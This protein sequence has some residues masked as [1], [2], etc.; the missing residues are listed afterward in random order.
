MIAWTWL[1]VGTVAGCLFGIVFGVWFLI[2]L[3]EDLIRANARL[4]EKNERL[5]QRIKLIGER[6]LDGTFGE[7]GG[8]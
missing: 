7:G 2:K 8:R 3:Q 5:R 6:K 1:V 4:T